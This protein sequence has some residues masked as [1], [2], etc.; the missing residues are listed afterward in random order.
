M[1]DSELNKCA[2][3][4]LIS[5]IYFL[6]AVTVARNC[7]LLLAAE[8]YW[9]VFSAQASID[10]GKIRRGPKCTLDTFNCWLVEN[11]CAIII[12]SHYSLVP[13]HIQPLS[14]IR[15]AHITMWSGNFSTTERKSIVKE[16]FSITSIHLDAAFSRAMLLHFLLLTTSA[17]PHITQRAQR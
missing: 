5:I 8:V 1:F 15:A 17:Q 7:V 16:R 10:N 13:L 9:L 12:E 6:F 4:A 2:S 14:W 3:I 11:K